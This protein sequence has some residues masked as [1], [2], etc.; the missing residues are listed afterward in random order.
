MATRPFAITSIC[1]TSLTKLSSSALLF[2]PQ[3]I[4]KFNLP[5]R[6]AKNKGDPDRC[7]EIDTLSSAQIR[8]LLKGEITSVD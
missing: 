7:V 2:S 8:E 6:P 1:M 4:K 3:Q 5:T